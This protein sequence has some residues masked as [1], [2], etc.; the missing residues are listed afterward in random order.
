MLNFIWL[1]MIIVSFIVAIINGR[2]DVLARAVTSS[3]QTGVEIALGML[4]VMTLWLGMFA[5]AEKAGLIEKLARLLR[6]IMCYLF[7]E[8][9]ADNPAMGAMIFNISANMLGM[10][11]A[12][13]PFGLKAMQELQKL[14][15]H[16]GIASNSMC[17][18]LAI[19][20]SSVQLIPA[21]AMAV[22]AANGGSHA[23]RVLFTSLFATI[24][25]TIV[26]VMIAKLCE[27][28]KLFRIKERH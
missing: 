28:A 17:T 20:T 14:N 3:A 2:V 10:A 26:A 19:N 8:V 24:I 7:P 25:S 21:T 16:A 12:A 15:K 4:A 5:I 23:S 27:K 11:N 22:L 18:F 1:F 13:T 9:P 6:P